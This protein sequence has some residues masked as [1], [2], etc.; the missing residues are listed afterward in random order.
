MVAQVRTVRIVFVDM[1]SSLLAYSKSDS[2]AVFV[3]GSRRIFPGLMS[4]WTQPC[5]HK[6]MKK[7]PIAFTLS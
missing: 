4:R 2:F 6:C 5:P 7:I 1:S 3:R